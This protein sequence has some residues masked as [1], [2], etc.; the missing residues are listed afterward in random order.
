VTAAAM[1][2]EI[3]RTGRLSRTPLVLQSEQAEC[4]LACIAMIAG[5]HGRM[6]DLPT[7]RSRVGDAGLGLGLRELMQLAG[8]LGLHARPLRLEP[9][10]LGELRCPA[11][12]H[13]D[14]D[15]YVVL[16]RVRRQGI[17]ILDPARGRRELTWKRSAGTSPASRWN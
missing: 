2:P 7:L 16:D 5:H 11:V 4:G 3:L 17:T 10:E 15:H 14:L 6:V 1:V 8:S 12:L 9:E 13:W